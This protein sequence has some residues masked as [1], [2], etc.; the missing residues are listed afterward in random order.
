MRRTR[1]LTALAGAGTDG[2]AR[3]EADREAASRQD[4]AS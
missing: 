1:D 2:Q 3:R 4:A